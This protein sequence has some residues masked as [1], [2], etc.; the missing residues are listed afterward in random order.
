[1]H[2][3]K[4]PESDGLPTLFLQMY[5]NIVGQKVQ[6]LSLVILNM[7]ISLEKFSV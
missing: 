1:M 5:W 4:S 3:L 6:E 7:G 2:P